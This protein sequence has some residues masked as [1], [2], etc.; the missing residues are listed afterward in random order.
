MKK[1]ITNAEFIVGKA[2]DTLRSVLHK[3][4][5]NLVAIVDPPR[6]GLRIISF[7]NFSDPKTVL[8]IRACERINTLIYVSCDQNGLVS[9]ISGLCKPASKKMKGRP[10]KPIKVKEI[11]LKFQAISVDL[12]PHTEGVERVILFQRDYDPQ[13]I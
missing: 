11:P 2:E 8:A 9:N 1:G 10:F 12:F 4:Y 6:A 5:H 13:Y 7:C 3:P